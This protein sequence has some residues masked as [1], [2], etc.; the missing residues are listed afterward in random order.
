[1]AVVEV[2]SVRRTVLPTSPRTARTKNVAMTITPETG[3][4]PLNIPYAPQKVTHTDLIADYVTVPRPGLIESVVYSNVQRPKMSFELE[5]HD[6][7]ITA[8]SGKSTTLVRAISVIQAIQNMARKGTR[9]RIAYGALESGLWFIISM[10][11]TSTKRDPINDEIVGATV[12]LEALRG[13]NA[14]SGTGTGSGPVSGGATTTTKPTT[15]TT[16]TKTPTGSTKSPSAPAARY[17]TV[18]SGDTLWAISLKYY[19]TGSKW[20]TLATANKIID[21]RKLKVGTKLRVP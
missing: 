21:P 15:P 14:I 4:T 9:V 18:K 13:D 19:G 16:G 1:M 20:T 12:Q 3:G 10:Q 11:V 7:K 5:I 8:T 6:K 2:M 17:Y